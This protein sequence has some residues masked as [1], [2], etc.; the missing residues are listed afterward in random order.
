MNEDT[1]DAVNPLEIARL[2]ATL[3]LT[4]M[5]V[6][7]AKKQNEPLFAAMLALCSA[8]KNW[9]GLEYG[10]LVE[11]ALAESGVTL[12]DWCTTLESVLVRHVGRR[13]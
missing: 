12:L 5:T 2:S 6:T 1:L 13:G 4:G 3:L 7:Y 10:Q 8:S 11:E 9:P